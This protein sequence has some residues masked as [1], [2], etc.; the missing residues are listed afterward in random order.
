MVKQ[1]GAP[2]TLVELGVGSAY[3]T[4]VLITALLELRPRLTFIPVDV[5]AQALKLGSSNRLN[6]AADA[7]VGR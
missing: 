7:A 3:K 5:S 6:E 4:K 1:A 2:A